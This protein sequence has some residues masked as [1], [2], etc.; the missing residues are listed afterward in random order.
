[1]NSLMSG[2]CV[3]TLSECHPWQIHEELARQWEGLCHVSASGR[4]LRA[5]W[6]RVPKELPPL[7]PKLRRP[8]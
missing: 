6:P 3:Q 1:M 2:P 4:E 8:V 5:H 7:T